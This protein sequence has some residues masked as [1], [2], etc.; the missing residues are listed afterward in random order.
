MRITTLSDG[1]SLAKEV[2]IDDLTKI[3]TLNDDILRRLI[4]ESF[5][6]I[7]LLMIIK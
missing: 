7:T 1:V 6:A 5:P 4:G 2:A 3:T